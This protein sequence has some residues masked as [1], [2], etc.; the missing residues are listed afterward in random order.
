MTSATVGLGISQRRWEKVSYQNRF[1][2]SSGVPIVISQVQTYNDANFVSTRQRKPLLTSFEVALEEEESSQLPH[3][4]EILGYFVI[5]STQNSQS[6]R[7]W[8]DS[9]AEIVFEVRERK[10]KK[11]KR[12]RREREK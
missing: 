6:Q 3:A 9:D 8:Q 12:E 1:P 7:F 11:K 4:T 10:R 2:T 5:Q